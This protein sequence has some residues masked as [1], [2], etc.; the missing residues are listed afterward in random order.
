MTSLAA[1]AWF[2]D[3]ATY[4]EPLFTGLM[5]MSG[6][7][8]C[9]GAGFH[10]AV[11]H[12]LALLAALQRDHERAESLF[13]A[14]EQLE[15]SMDHAPRLCKTWMAWADTI[16][17]RTSDDLSE[18]VRALEL[19]DRAIVLAAE[20]ELPRTHER[21]CAQRAALASRA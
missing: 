1:S 15:S 4:A 3:D 7:L 8:A 21:A 10:G 6:Q 13:E 5:R 11:D 18:R 2:L 12:Y 16:A 17:R 14:A 19:L 20:R 9:S